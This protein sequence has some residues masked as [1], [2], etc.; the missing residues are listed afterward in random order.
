[1]NI[2]NNGSR[3]VEQEQHAQANKFPALLKTDHGLNGLES[4]E[5]ET[6]EIPQQTAGKAH[7][8][9]P[10]LAREH[11]EEAAVIFQG[12]GYKIA[13]SK[14]VHEGRK[15]HFDTL[16]TLEKKWPYL[17]DSGIHGILQRQEEKGNAFKGRFNKAYRLD[18]TTWYSVTDELV[19]RAMDQDG[20]IWFDVP[21]A[22]QCHSIIAGTIY[23][24][25]R[26]HLLAFLADNPEFRGVPY[27]K[28]NKAALARVLNRSLS[29]IKREFKE[30]LKHKCI[31]V[32]PKQSKEYTIC[33]NA[34]LVV[35]DAMQKHALKSGSSTEGNGSSTEMGIG[36]ST[37]QTGSSTEQ[38]GS[39]TEKNGSSA[40]NN[41]HYKPF[42]KHI[43][44][45]HSPNAS[46]GVCGECADA[47]GAAKESGHQHI[48]DN[49]GSS[50]V[51]VKEH[52]V[53]PASDDITFQS[54]RDIRKVTDALKGL[55]SDSERMKLSDEGIGVAH[56]VC[57]DKI[58]SQ[59]LIAVWDAKTETEII[60]TIAPGVRKCAEDNAKG[61][62]LSSR[63]QEIAFVEGLEFASEVFR[64][65]HSESKVML[66]QFKGRGDFI[67]QIHDEM[68]RADEL[69]DISAHAK[70]DLLIEAIRHFNKNGWP[71]YSN[72]NVEFTVSPSKAV[73]EAAR[74]FLEAI[75]D[76]SADDVWKVL[77]DCVEVFK[78]NDKPA[79]Y[80]PLWKAR[81][82]IKPLF[83]FK[84]WDD[85]KAE[86]A[87]AESLAS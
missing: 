39:S 10:I 49:T 62:G 11:G 8:F 61:L 14:K 55:L 70:A 25:V 17:R 30:L 86:L 27:Y 67:I 83:L 13:K 24:N 15:W 63:V 46:R 53:M 73:G 48:S 52:G 59:E 4:S 79:K 50:T 19:K 78:L 81:N 12:L 32:N 29:T 33:N 6:S 40:E 42:E 65:V 64:L 41:T 28:V 35:P 80:D 76:L 85:I 75:P 34:D 2:V 66:P 36:S 3:K 74:A 54:I 57:T 82:G 60:A 68:K 1:V 31:S 84:F 45:D 9:C 22:I 7:C 20:K 51:P 56:E 5:E 23:Q 69:T 38:I 37:D 71:T 21:V 72:G 18:R 44:K 26:Y 77:A 58:S 47:A 43:H 87:A 16:E